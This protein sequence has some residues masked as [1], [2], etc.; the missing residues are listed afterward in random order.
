MRLDAGS[1]RVEFHTTVDWQEE[2]TLLKVCFPLAV[3]APQRD[4]RDAVRLRGAPDALVDELGPRALRGA[5]PP[6]GGLS[7]HGFG[8]ALLNDCKYG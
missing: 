8:V 3:H 1:R 5:R 4:L 2:H 7:E 6:L